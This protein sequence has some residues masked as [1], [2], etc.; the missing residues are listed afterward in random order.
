M[1]GNPGRKKSALSSKNFRIFLYGNTVSVLGIWIQRLALGWQAWQLSESSLVVGVVAAGQ[2]LPFLLLTP[3]FG[4]LVD[5]IRPRYGAI[6]MHVIFMSIALTLGALTIFDRVSIELLVLLSF[7]HGVA[8]SAYSPFRLALIPDLVPQDQFPSAVAISAV[9]FNTTRFIGP[10]IAGAIV[11]FYGLGFAYFANSISYLP[12]ILSLLVIRTH[13]KKPEPSAKKKYSEELM[14]G[15]RYTRDHPTIRKVI[16]VAGVSTFF[17]RGVLELMPAFAALIFAG[18]S[19]ELAAL[20]AAAGAGA[21]LTSLIFSFASL[22]SYLGQ[23]VVVGALGVAA[24]MFLFAMA[25]TLAFG[26]FATALLGVFSSMVSIGSQSE[27]QIKVDDRL[28]GRVLSLWTLLLIGGPAVGSI[29]AGW[30]AA[31]FGSTNT[32]LSFAIVSLILIIA[33]VMQK[34]NTVPSRGAP[35]TGH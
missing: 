34:S 8:N 2:F 14:E 7:C 10:G 4:V 1:S 13:R 5:R 21:I 24:S 25:E 22:H 6:V 29:V 15:L 17:G 9:I 20:M 32:L 18:G 3:F 16:L 28:R 11:T 26:I 12:V 30:L 23:T 27:V 35:E 33:V 31:E 19:A